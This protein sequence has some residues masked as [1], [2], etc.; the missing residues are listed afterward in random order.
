MYFVWFCVC[1]LCGYLRGILFCE[2]DVERGGLAELGEEEK[3][4][5]WESCELER[6]GA[7]APC[8]GGGV[9]LI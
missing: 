4:G 2:D 7:G 3:T 5:A 8:V 6:V 9:E 1:L